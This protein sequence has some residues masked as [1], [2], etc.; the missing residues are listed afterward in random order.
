[1]SPR[2]VFWEES[3][4]TQATP[5]VNWDAIPPAGQDDIL[6]VVGFAIHNKCLYTRNTSL[7]SHR[8]VFFV[9]YVT[10][11]EERSHQVT[12]TKDINTLSR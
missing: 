10:S 6:V 1:M 12:H 8:L 7:V 3:A 4:V 2:L 5:Q 9:E 11:T